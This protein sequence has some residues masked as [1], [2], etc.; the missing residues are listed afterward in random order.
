[1]KRNISSSPCG[2][3]ETPP[4]S[5]ESQKFNLRPQQSE[6]PPSSVEYEKRAP[7]S[8]CKMAPSPS[9]FGCHFCR[10]LLDF[11]RLASALA[12]TLRVFFELLLRNRFD[13]FL[14]TEFDERMPL[15]FAFAMNSPFSP[16]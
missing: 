4:A 12:A 6:Q 10:Y 5:V 2:T 1:M 11:L 13:A 16:L 9:L 3:L 15:F 8:L 7:A 14:A